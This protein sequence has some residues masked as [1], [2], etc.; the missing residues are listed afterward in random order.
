MSRT[1]LEHKDDEA[2]IPFSDSLHF[3]DP[4]PYHLTSS[5]KRANQW[6][7]WSEDIIPH[8]IVPYLSYIQETLSLHHANVP[9]EHYSNDGECGAG[10][11]TRSIKVAC[12]LLTR[13]KKSPSS[14]V[15][16]FLPRFSIFV[17]MCTHGSLSGSRL[18][19]SGLTIS[20]A[21]SWRKHECEW[22]L[23]QTS[24]VCNEGLQVHQ[25][26]L[27][28]IVEL[29]VEE[30]TIVQMILHGVLE[31]VLPQP[32]TIVVR[33]PQL[34]HSP[35][36][37]KNQNFGPASIMLLEDPNVAVRPNFTLPEHEA[38][39]QQLINDRLTNEQAAQSLVALWMLSNNADIEHWNLRQHHLCKTRLREE[40]EEEE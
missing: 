4:V 35:G 2:T 31:V 19:S 18:M 5:Q 25:V 9:G 15:L 38:A 17:A 13:S 40:E 39:H 33:T 20:G 32:S 24:Q 36:S 23:L 34:P 14:P 26:Q 27:K 3:S 11:R 6:Q 22:T 10:C 7:R 8:M 21:V 28:L 1:E 37:P 12:V 16:V 29:K 30:D